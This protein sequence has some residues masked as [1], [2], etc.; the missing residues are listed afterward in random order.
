MK[1]FENYSTILWDFDGVILDSMDIRDLGFIKVLSEL[2]HQKKDIDTLITF[3]RANG[4]LSRYFKFRYFYEKILG[5]DISEQCVIDL[6]A[7]FSE[8]VTDL[9]INKDLIMPKVLEFIQSNYKMYNFHIVSG[10]DQTEL[11]NVCKGLKLD[12][13]FESIHG[14]PTAKTQLVADVLQAHQ[15][16]PEMVCL[17]GDSINDFHAADKNAIDFYGY[18]NSGLKSVGNGYIDFF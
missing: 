10:S 14:S 18:N 9:L 17:I 2:G 13:Y 6:A 8:Q 4:G 11:R 3:H 1:L 5:Q 15:Y 7:K 12:T 16:R